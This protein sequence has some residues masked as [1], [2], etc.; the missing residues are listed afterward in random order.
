MHVQIP[1]VS[2]F[3]LQKATTLV[4]D[5]EKPPT[6][7]EDLAPGE[8]EVLF[9]A[10]QRLRALLNVA[11]TGIKY[12]CE[13]APNGE[14]TIHRALFD[15]AAT[16]PLRHELNGPLDALFFDRADLLSVALKIVTP[17]GSA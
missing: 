16:A 8:Q 13:I 15:A 7:P 9:A 12:W 17:H 3:M 4:I 2:T 5:D 11:A 10:A 6:L 1:A 14:T